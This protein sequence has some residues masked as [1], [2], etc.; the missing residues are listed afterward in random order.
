LEWF[1]HGLTD[2]NARG[3]LFN[4]P[5]F[6]RFDRP[7]AVDGYAETVNDPPDKGLADGY[8]GNPARSFYKIAFFDLVI[9][10][11]NNSTDIVFFQIQC[12]PGNTLRKIKEFS[13]HDIFKS[14]DPGNTATD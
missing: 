1:L 11:K 2:N 8:L 5:E 4:V 7:F 9:F 14:I 10:S 3:H 13:R 12:H 6:F